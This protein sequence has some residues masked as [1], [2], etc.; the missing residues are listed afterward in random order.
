MHMYIHKIIIYMY[1]YVSR[2][3]HYNSYLIIY[4]ETNDE[5]WQ[6]HRI[7]RRNQVLLDFRNLDYLHFL[8][9]NI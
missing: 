2:N 5:T 4:Q 7:K 3:I 6:Q 8:Q 1:I 9:I